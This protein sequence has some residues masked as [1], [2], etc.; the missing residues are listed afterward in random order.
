[1]KECN[2]CKKVV[3]SFIKDYCELPRKRQL[4][5]A[6]IDLSNSMSDQCEEQEI[7]LPMQRIKRE[8][9]A[10]PEVI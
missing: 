4:F 6:M 7:C 5:N 3:E 2:I 10:K 1:M 9:R 8:L